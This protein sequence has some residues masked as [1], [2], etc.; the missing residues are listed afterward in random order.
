MH[1]Y[2]YKRE[3]LDYLYERIQ[4]LP[5]KL[6]VPYPCALEVYCHYSRDQILAALGHKRPESIREGVVY[7]QDKHTDIF[8][9]TLNKSSKEFSDTTLYEDYSINS[10]LF[11]WQS[12]S[13]T[14]VDSPTG[15]R[16]I[17][18][19][20]TGNS[21]LF[22][23]RERKQDMY[24]RTMSYTFLGPAHYVSHTGSRPIPIIYKLDQA[25]PAQYI[26]TT[27]SSGVL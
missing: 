22:F 3:F 11:H 16:Y 27:D 18:Q 5:Q 23:V 20:E 15:Q 1:L 19:N 12:Q 14:A 2:L 9:V 10:Q 4:I 26:T 13:T 24:K 17:Q 25:I 8:L 6:T 7:L 21:V